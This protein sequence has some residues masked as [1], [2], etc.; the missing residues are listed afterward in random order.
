MQIH[1]EHDTT[2]HYAATDDPIVQSLRL[3]PISSS[4][5]TINEWQV[6]I[7][8]RLVL[9]RYKDG[10]GNYLATHTLAASSALRLSVRGRVQTFSRDGIHQGEEPLPPVFFLCGTDLTMAGPAIIEVAC[11]GVSQSGS[12]RDSDSNVIDRLRRLV[13][14]LRDRIEYVAERTG[15]EVSAEQALANGAGRAQEHAHVLIAAVQSIGFPAR[16]VSGYR[17]AVESDAVTLHEWT[18]IFCPTAVGWDSM[19]SIAAQPTIV[20]CELPADAICAMR[21]QF[22]QSRLAVLPSRAKSPAQPSRRPPPLR[23]SCEPHPA[24]VSSR[25]AVRAVRSKA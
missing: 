6:Q 11:Q 17:R 4:T 5:Q 7:D 22:A 19:Q 16:F 12:Q 21:R 14:T 20:T 18:E 24:K 9:A 2:L 15:T 1:I 25:A 10:F 8:G 3:W 13:N 23:S